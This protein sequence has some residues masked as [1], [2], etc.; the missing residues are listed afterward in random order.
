M[1][2]I[3][4]RNIYTPSPNFKVILLKEIEKRD[5]IQNYARTTLLIGHALEVRGMP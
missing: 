1:I 2:C 4:S 5:N 3:F